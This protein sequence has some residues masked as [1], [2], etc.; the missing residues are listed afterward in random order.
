MFIIGLGFKVPEICI[1]KK[2]DTMAY[3]KV[4]GIWSIEY[5]LTFSFKIFIMEQTSNPPKLRSV[6][7]SF[8]LP[9][10]R[11]PHPTTINCQPSTI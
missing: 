9:A 3:T 10:S 5:G 2:S 11:F 4:C 7:A 6:R 8:Q 1:L